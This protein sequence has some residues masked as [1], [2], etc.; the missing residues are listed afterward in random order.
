MSFSFYFWPK[1]NYF[2]LERGMDGCFWR[3][4]GFY[5]G[6]ILPAG[7][8]YSFSP[9]K[10]YLINCI[11]FSMVQVT[12]EKWQRLNIPHLRLKWLSFNGHSH[13]AELQGP[14]QRC[15]ERIAMVSG[16]P[17]R[18]NKYWLHW[19]YVGLLFENFK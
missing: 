1:I 4:S 19:L 9:S 5:C 3:S 6:S 2:F 12:R 18:H 11:L 7:H 8:L 14:E 13:L 17:V 10:S 16:W 15:K